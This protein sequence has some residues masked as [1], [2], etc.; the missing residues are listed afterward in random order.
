MPRAKQE[1]GTCR[2]THCDSYVVCV[3][4][5][6]CSC[7]YQR[8]RS[9]RE[10]WDAPKQRKS[11]SDTCLYCD[12]PPKALDMCQT[13]YRRV[14]VTGDPNGLK[15]RANG[16]GHVTKNGYLKVWDPKQGKARPQHR[17]TMEEHLGRLLKPYE[18]VHHI[19]GDKLD[20]RI[21]NLELWIVTQPCGQRLADLIQWIVAEYPDEV[22]KELND[23]NA[24]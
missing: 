15:R 8:F 7:H 20:N 2:L 1:H 11:Q 9:G 12:K 22:R 19:N 5:R 3:E 4:E 14:K 24:K 23:D 6:L 17:L 10:D 18:N 13:H 16:E 21:E